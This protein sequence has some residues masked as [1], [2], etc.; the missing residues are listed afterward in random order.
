MSTIKIKQ[1]L[2]PLIDTSQPRPQFPDPY[3]N[4]LFG[5]DSTGNLT[6]WR[7]STQTWDVPTQEEINENVPRYI[8]NTNGTFISKTDSNGNLIDYRF[9]KQNVSKISLNNIYFSEI[10]SFTKEYNSDTIL[11]ILP[12]TLLPNTEYLI[13]K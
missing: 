1:V 3:A 7:D 2:F 10:E 6:I 5:G 8:T 11:M 12:N 4:V 13:T 9:L